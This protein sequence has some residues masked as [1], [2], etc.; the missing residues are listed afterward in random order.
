MRDFDDGVRI[1]R[2][3]MV[4]ARADGT[5]TF[6]LTQTPDRV[7]LYPG[8]GNSAGELF[9]SDQKGVLYGAELELP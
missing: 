5:E 3:E 6:V 9:F 4:L 7:E 2:S 1:T 8:W